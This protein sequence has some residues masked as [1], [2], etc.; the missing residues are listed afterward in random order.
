MVCILE[1]IKLTFFLEHGNTKS[2]V[3]PVHTYYFPK[4]PARRE[5]REERTREEGACVFPC[6]VSSAAEKTRQ[7]DKISVEGKRRL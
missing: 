3:L 7:S 1:K 4:A 5:K 2:I 6:A